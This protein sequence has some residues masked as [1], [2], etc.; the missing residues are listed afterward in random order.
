MLKIT[1]KCADVYNQPGIDISIWQHE[2]DS[3]LCMVG[4]SL[5]S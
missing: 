5:F 4:T 2:G 1:D 3:S